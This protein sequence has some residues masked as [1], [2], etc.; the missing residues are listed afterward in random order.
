M[1]G[2][3]RTEIMR[4]ERVIGGEN[5]AST[6]PFA[7]CSHLA[8]QRTSDFGKGVQRTRAASKGQKLPLNP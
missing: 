3:Q 4:K 8:A 5:L 1:H 7:N 2:A 6:V